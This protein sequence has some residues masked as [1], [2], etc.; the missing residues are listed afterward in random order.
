[1]T[2]ELAVGSRTRSRD[3]RAL[4]TE[5][6]R[7]MRQQSRQGW[8]GPGPAARHSVQCLLLLF[9][10]WLGGPLAADVL[11]NQGVLRS[12]P[13]FLRAE[14]AFVL[15]AKMDG[16][17]LVASWRI[18]PGYYLYRSRTTL[19]AEPAVKSPSAEPRSAA[20]PGSPPAN[21]ERKPGAIKPTPSVS[22]PPPNVSSAAAPAPSTSEV[23]PA[24]KATGRR[25]RTE[26]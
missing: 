25:V 8:P 11:S 15:S 18:A 21:S 23:V 17:A 10:C 5:A 3:D 12:Q 14:E 16:A 2:R 9:V 22:V 24:P 6:S 1:M 20:R 7:R 4:N 26:L 13:D 19:T